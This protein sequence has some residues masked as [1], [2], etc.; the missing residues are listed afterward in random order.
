[1]RQCAVLIC[2]WPSASVV[3]KHGG[4]GVMLEALLGSGKELWRHYDVEGGRE[5]PTAQELAGYD[6]IVL[7]GSRHSVY[8]DQPWIGEVAELVRGAVAREQRVLGVCFGAQLLARAL[9]GEVKAAD[10]GWEVGARE[11]TLDAASLPRRY[12]RDLPAYTVL[13]LHRDAVVELPVGATLLGSSRCCANEIFAIGDNVLAVQGHPEFRVDTLEDLVQSRV[14]AGVI[15]AH[16]AD[17]DSVRR[18][19]PPNPTNPNNQLRKLCQ[20]FLHTP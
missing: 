13:Q 2:G 6:G 19:P 1:M 9:G 18:T 15:P 5:M 16:Q 4:Y 7:S 8:D 20:D 17:L 12:K 14:D 10:V 11:V 3:G